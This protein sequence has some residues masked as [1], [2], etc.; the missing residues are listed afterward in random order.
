MASGVAQAREPALDEAGAFVSLAAGSRAFLRAC[1]RWAGLRP[2]DADPQ[3][4]EDWI[5]SRGEVVKGFVDGITGE[6]VPGDVML[7]EY[8]LC[9]CEVNGWPLPDRASA[10]DTLVQN[11]LRAQAFDPRDTPFHSESGVVSPTDSG[12][13]GDEQAFDAGDFPLPPESEPVSPPDK[14]FIPGAGVERDSVVEALQRPASDD[15]IAFAQRFV[16]W[17]RLTNQCGTYSSREFAELTDQFCEA[18]DLP[19]MPDNRFRPALERMT[20]D[21]SKAELDGLD[22]SRRRRRRRRMWTIHETETD[23]L[24]GVPWSE[25]RAA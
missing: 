13:A 16:E 7:S 1:A 9:S 19:R 2:R 3:S 8:Y 6:Y 12:S 4:F 14:P 11:A 25:L 24:L 20:D 15:P 18:E 22:A 21:V 5:A 23:G 17:V 10:G